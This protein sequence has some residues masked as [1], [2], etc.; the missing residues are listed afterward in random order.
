MRAQLSSDSSVEAPRCGITTVSYTHLAPGTLDEKSLPDAAVASSTD[1][2]LSW[3]EQKALQASER[4]RKNEL[5]KTEHQISILEN[6][7]T[8]IDHLLTL[9][10]VY[11]NSVRCQELVKEQQNNNLTLAQLYEKWEKLAE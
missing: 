3:Q 9:E 8:E 7:N 6:R 4:K 11:A 10:E 5:E 1:S 2:K